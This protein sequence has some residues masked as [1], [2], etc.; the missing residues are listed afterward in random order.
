MIEQWRGLMPNPTNYTEEKTALS[1]AWYFQT[2][3]PGGI[4]PKTATEF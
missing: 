3:M 4:L 2:S 1:I